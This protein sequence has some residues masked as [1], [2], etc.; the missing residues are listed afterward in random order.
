MKT[1]A[2]RFGINIA[3]FAVIVF[4]TLAGCACESNSRP[5]Q[6]TLTVAPAEEISV[7]GHEALS[8][9][10]KSQADAAAL[11]THNEITV[12]LAVRLH[13]D[14]RIVVASEQMHKRG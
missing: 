13:S 12:D 5:V 2:N 9:S 8:R 6:N 1:Q 7:S 11:A 10:F 4:A 14:D 3:A